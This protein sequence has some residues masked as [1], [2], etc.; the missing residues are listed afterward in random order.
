MSA[1]GIIEVTDFMPIGG[2]D[3]PSRIVRSVRAIEGPVPVFID[4]RPAFDYARQGHETTIGGDGLT[5][6]FVAGQTRGTL[7][8]THPVSG[9]GG[10]AA[11]RFTL[12]KG[13]WAAV[14]FSLDASDDVSAFDQPSI[15]ALERETVRYWRDWAARIT[16][17]GRWRDTMI[18]SALTLKLLTSR[19]HGSIIAAPTFGLPEKIGGKLNWDYRYCWIRDST[20]SVYAFVRLGLRDEAIA[21]MRWVE[22]MYAA[23]AAHDGE[24]R[25]M[26]RTDGGT[27]IEEKPLKDFAGYRGSRP[28]MIGNAAGKEYQLDLY[29]EL[30]DAIALYDRHVTKI[31]HDLWQRVIKT[32][33]YVCA[34]WKKA[35]A[36]IWEVRGKPRQFL[37]TRLMCWVALDRALRLA[38]EEALPAETARWQKERAKIYDDIF[39]NFW[40]EKLQSFVQYKHADVVDA[41]ALLMPLVDFISP[42]DSRWLSTQNRIAERLGSGVLVHRNRAAEDEPADFSHEGSFNACSFWYIAALA[43]S[44]DRE[45][46]LLLFARMMS[47][48][49]HLGL[50]AEEMDKDGHQLGNFPQGLTHLAL[51][52]AIFALEEAE[53]PERAPAK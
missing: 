34:H 27:K 24:L 3:A 1:A 35:D 2:L 51:I 4:C 36:G 39:E 5:V 19:R 50:F 41:S 11:A 18:R 44:G 6:I 14:M 32:A 15:A 45:E 23:N 12:A 37:H 16:Y 30:M 10:G 21:F 47:Y 20:F 17:D 43:R 38:R 42:H 7:R 25:L 53:N 48:G 33:D 26:Y 49:N 29:G 9:E 8:A 52:N 13:E 40:N 22:K 46:A 28:V 31:S